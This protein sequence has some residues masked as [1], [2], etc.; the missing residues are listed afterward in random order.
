MYS[1]RFFDRNIVS[2]QK[3]GVAEPRRVSH[4]MEKDLFSLQPLGQKEQVF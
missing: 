1:S 3:Y 4:V 2:S